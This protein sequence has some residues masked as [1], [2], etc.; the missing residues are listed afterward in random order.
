MIFRHM[1]EST[2]ASTLAFA[3]KGARA[4]GLDDEMTE[5][6]LAFDRE[7]VVTYPV[8]LDSGKVV[9]FKGMRIQHNGARGVYKGGIRYSP[10]VDLDDTRALAMLMTW[11]CALFSLPLGGAKGSVICSPERMSKG[12][13]ERLS[14]GYAI[15]MRD[16]FGP[17]KDVPAPDV[18][19]DEQVMAWMFDTLS[20]AEGRTIA[21]AFTGKPDYLLGSKGRKG[22]T[23]LGVAYSARECAS[24]LD[25]NLRRA[26]A[27]IQGLGKV[28]Y[29]TAK[30]LHEMGVRVVAMSDSTG[31]IYYGEG[32]DPDELRAALHTEGKTS[33]IRDLDLGKA[34]D[35]KY[36]GAKK[37]SNE[38]LLTLECDMLVPA[39]IEGVIN[40]KNADDV[41]AKFVVEGANGPTT[42]EG[43]EILCERKVTVVPDIL[44]NAGGVVVSSFELSQNLQELYWTED[45]VL[46]ELEKRIIDTFAEAWM[47]AKKGNTSLRES[48]YGLAID[49]VANAM[50]ARGVMF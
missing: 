41:H 17:G 4:L 16:V 37:L 26:T 46:G 47:R 38:E 12:E 50:N 25:V 5:R 22:A 20:R 14:R 7:I 19:T 43:D 39:A 32:I 27:V 9:N 8:R 6:L 35:G 30:S 2:L 21:G 18:K 28:A 36:G 44:A 34:L 10:A 3:D 48:S 1:S 31:A 33:K 49:R 15:A 40:A 29:S 45:K 13:L 24:R 23:G 42:V 11:K